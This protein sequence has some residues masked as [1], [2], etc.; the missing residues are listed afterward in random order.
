MICPYVHHC[1]YSDQD[2]SS[3][4]HH[5]PYNC[6]IFKNLVVLDLNEVAEDR[7]EGKLTHI[8]GDKNARNKLDTL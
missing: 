1:C 2:E 7:Q 6:K 3:E 8:I 4:C 5:D